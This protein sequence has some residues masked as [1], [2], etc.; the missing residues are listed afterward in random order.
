MYGTKVKCDFNKAI[1]IHSGGTTEQHFY[2]WEPR[3][4]YLHKVKKA[5]GA[6]NM[7]S[8]GSNK[9]LQNIDPPYR[10]IVSYPFIEKGQRSHKYAFLRASG[11]TL[12]RLGASLWVL[13][14]GEKSSILHPSSW[15]STE[16]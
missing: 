2:V 7:H 11:A 14:I 3:C 16:Q 4:G 13:S 15:G 9:L 10:K 12:L 8:K 1:N 5:N 6:I